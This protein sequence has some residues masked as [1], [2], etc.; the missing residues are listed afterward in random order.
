MILHTL[1]L[2]IRKCAATVRL[3]MEKYQ[4]P[5]AT[6]AEAAAP[7]GEDAA[8]AALHMPTSEAL[9]DVLAAALEISGLQEILGVDQPTVIT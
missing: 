5:P 9:K 3:Y 1:H 6:A 8:A 7:E 2:S 4:A